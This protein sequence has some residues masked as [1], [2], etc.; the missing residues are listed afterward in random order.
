MSEQGVIALEQGV[1][2]EQG[3]ILPGQGAIAREMVLHGTSSLIYNKATAARN[4]SACGGAQR[5]SARC[6]A[7][8]CLFI[9]GDFV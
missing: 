4:A 8:R 9:R 1:A 2:S 5:F 7:A 3:V 6:G